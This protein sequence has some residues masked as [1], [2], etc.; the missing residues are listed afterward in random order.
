MKTEK[1]RTRPKAIDNAT[2]ITIRLSRDHVER[3]DK[4]VKDRGF[5]SRN[6]AVRNWIEIESPV[7]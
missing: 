2:T 4:I 3:L 7:E 5:S 1:P 6:E